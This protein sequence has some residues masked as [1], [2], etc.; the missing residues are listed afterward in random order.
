MDKTQEARLE[1]LQFVV[2]EAA[3]RPDFVHH[4]W[5]SQWHL[6]IVERI[7]LELLAVYPQA[8]RTMVLAMVWLHDYGKIINFDRQ[9]DRE[10]IDAGRD[11]LIKLGFDKSFAASVADNIAH[12]DT[13][14]QLDKASIEVQILSTADG[15]SHLVGPFVELYWWENPG[16]SPSELLQRNITKLTTDWQK[17]IVLPEARSA[18]EARHKAAMERAGQLPELFIKKHSKEF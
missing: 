9:Y 4:I 5:F 8:N 13:K 7:A 18:F 2:R 1:Q 3:A 11:V 15:C 6:E 17:K 16:L 14:S 10:Y 12:A